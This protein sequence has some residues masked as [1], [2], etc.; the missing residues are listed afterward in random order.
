MFDQSDNKPRSG[1]GGN[2]SV[3]LEIYRVHFALQIAVLLCPTVKCT[4]TRHLS[5]DAH[6]V[7]SNTVGDCLSLSRTG[8]F[9]IGYFPAHHFTWELRGRPP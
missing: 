3:C 5:K 4:T 7:T 9:R 8:F 6:V 1:V 2:D